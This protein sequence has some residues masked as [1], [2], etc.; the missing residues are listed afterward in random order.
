M[1]IGYKGWKVEEEKQEGEKRRR[2][3]REENHGN[4]RIHLKKCIFQ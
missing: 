4:I 3:K 1:N 2:R